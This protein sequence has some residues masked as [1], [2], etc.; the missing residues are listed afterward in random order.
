MK[1]RGFVPVLL[2][3]LCLTVCVTACEKTQGGPTDVAVTFAEKTVTVEIGEEKSLTVT[4]NTEGL[5]FESK[6]PAIVTVTSDG[7]ITGIAEGSAEVTVTNAAGAGDSC[8]VTVT[9]PDAP[10]TT[11]TMNVSEYEMLVGETVPLR[12]TVKV[13]GTTVTDQ[14][15]CVDVIRPFGRIRGQR[16]RNCA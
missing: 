11:V 1:K 16:N 4:G 15:C 12:A 14:D 9:R 5:V 7:K 3:L 6:A 10:T 2:L 13:D 8:T